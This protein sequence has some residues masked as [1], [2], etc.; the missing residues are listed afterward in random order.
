MK[1]ILVI[2]L[3]LVPLTGIGQYVKIPTHYDSENT[4]KH[5]IKGHLTMF[6]MG[7]VKIEIEK[8]NERYITYHE[9]NPNKVKDEIDRVFAK[10]KPEYVS[11]T[12]GGYIFTIAV[13]NAKDDTKVI[14]YVQFRVNAYTQK[15]E[16]IKIFL[17]K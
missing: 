15:I 17:G 14:N 11:R 2:L 16:E 8:K 10:G 12:N 13:V 1:N 3:C 7:S 9:F 4:S 6:L 5:I